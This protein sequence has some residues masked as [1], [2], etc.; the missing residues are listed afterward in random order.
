MA[1]SA[2]PGPT[3]AVSDVATRYT[4]DGPVVSGPEPAMADA[5]EGMRIAFLVAN[6]GV[7]EREP[8]EPWEAVR[9][10]GGRAELIAPDGGDVQCFEHLD[11]TGAAPVDVTTEIADP[12]DYDALVLPGGVADA[13]QL[14]LDPHAVHFV[15]ACFDAGKP[16]GVICHGRGSWPTPECSAVG[17]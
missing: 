7:E 16:V 10:A 9:R 14:R 15:R 11:R 17:P 13:D 6:E 8:R 12:A 1:L 3:V 4:R 2:E 5:L